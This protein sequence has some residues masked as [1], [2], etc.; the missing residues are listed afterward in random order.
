MSAKTIM[1]FL[2]L[3]SLSVV[4]VLC[5]HAL[6]QRVTAETAVARPDILVAAAALPLA[7]CCGSKIW[8]GGRS[9]ELA[10]PIRFC[11]LAVRVV[12]PVLNSISRCAL[13]SM[14]LHC[15]LAS[16]PAG[17]KPRGSRQ[18]G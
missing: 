7:H 9:Q 8:P 6:P 18:A 3:I 13:K 4:V 10:S 12:I 11:A 2:F 5:L 15:V 14:G 17:H 1:T 16:R